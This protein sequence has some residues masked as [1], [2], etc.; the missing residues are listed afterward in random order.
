MKNIKSTI[1]RE[2]KIVGWLSK[3]III[4]FIAYNFYFGWNYEPK[5]E[6][7][8]IFDDI[9]LGLIYFLVGFILHIFLSYIKFKMNKYLSDINDRL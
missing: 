4:Y 7:E 2:I 6:L 8:N 5:S 1:L 9:L 3:I